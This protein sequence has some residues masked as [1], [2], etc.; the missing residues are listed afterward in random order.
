M[1]DKQFLGVIIGFVG[2]AVS[3][4]GATVIA[5]LIYNSRIN[6]LIKEARSNAIT[7]ALELENR[8]TRLEQ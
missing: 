7:A 8:F 1:T 3:M 5:A 4:V 6:D 2:M